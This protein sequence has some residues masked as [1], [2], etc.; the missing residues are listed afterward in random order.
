M[1]FS[2]TNS[3]RILGIFPFPSVSHQVVFNAYVEELLK[4]G[5]EVVVLTTHPS[6]SEQNSVKNLTEID[7]SNLDS[8]FDSKLGPSFTFAKR[9][10]IR[11]TD[12]LF[13][14]EIFEG[15]ASM[16]AEVFKNTQVK[17]MMDDKNQHFDL[18]VIEAL[19]NYHLISSKIWNAPVILISTLYGLPE[20]YEI[21]GAVSRH[22]VLYP[23]LLR[24]KFRDLSTWEIIKECYNE[25]KI[26]KK[27]QD[28][29]EFENALLKQ[30]FGPDTP[31]VQELKDNVAM[32]FLNSH[33][34]FADNRP[35][36]PGA[37][38]LG[39]LH[40]KPVRTLPEVELY[41]ANHILIVISVDK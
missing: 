29:E 19:M 34:L 20:S 7:I 32:L 10:V 31:T 37:V 30:N 8:V 9:G 16:I 28:I 2:T 21:I 35:V 15:L 13:E 18:I 14:T 11:D 17:S 33:P 39:A 36:P 22:P 6:Q 4:Y 25:Y 27:F 24:S 38:F 41:S 3:A 12:T 23:N 5:H 1:C 40:L 26:M